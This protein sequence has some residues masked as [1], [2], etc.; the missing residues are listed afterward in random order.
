MK[1]IT[2]DGRNMECVSLFKY[3]ALYYY[4]TFIETYVLADDCFKVSDYFSSFDI[5]KSNFD[6]GLVTLTNDTSGKGSFNLDKTPMSYAM[7]DL[8]N[9]YYKSLNLEISNIKIMILQLAN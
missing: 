9:N 6:L 2:D 4:T 3:K 8:T 1:F 7:L 5:N